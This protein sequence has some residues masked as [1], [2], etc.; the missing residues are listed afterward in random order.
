MKLVKHGT[1]SRVTIGGADVN[2]V[3]ATFSQATDG[4][5]AD[6]STLGTVGLKLLESF[7]MIVNQSAG[8]VAM[9]RLEKSTT[10][11]TTR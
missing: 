8:K 3:D 7:R 1:L 6:E 4:I 2:D 5:G 9:V 11:P 10:A